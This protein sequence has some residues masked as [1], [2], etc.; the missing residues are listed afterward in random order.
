MKQD[1]VKH[2]R[3]IQQILFDPQEDV[4][5]YLLQTLKQGKEAYYPKNKLLVDRQTCI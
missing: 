4:P 2:S 5:K 3:T 1:F